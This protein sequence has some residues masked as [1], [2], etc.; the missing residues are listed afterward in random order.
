MDKST[1]R[2]FINKWG[3]DKWDKMVKI[4]NEIEDHLKYTFI[5]K[6]NLLQALI[7][8]GDLLDK[9]HFEMQEFL[10]DSILNLII[11]E[12]LIDNFNLKKPE[13]LTR[14]K[15]MMTKN[16]YL[17]S[18]SKEKP[19]SLP[20]KQF[21]DLFEITLTEKHLSDAFEAILG[22]LYIDMNFDKNKIK[23]IILE[24][25]KIQDVNIDEMLLKEN[26]KDKKSLLNEWTQKEYGG[27]VTI[28]YPYTNKG[29]DHRP[30]FY[31]GLQLTNKEGKVIFQED[32]IGPYDRLKDGEIAISEKFLLKIA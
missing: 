25:I 15:S 32:K 24:I 10:G 12:Y 17:A 30:K 3:L 8:R 5:D 22:A 21:E 20:L 31:V 23:P 28:M 29:S 1:S 11:S 2:E 6:D 14:I 18:L 13:E 27:E 7:V 19:F 16:S 4:M 26:L 9:Q